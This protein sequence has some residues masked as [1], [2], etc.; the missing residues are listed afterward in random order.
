MK[1]N[2]TVT[3]GRRRNRTLIAFAAAG[4]MSA[5]GIG[6]YASWTANADERPA[7]FDDASSRLTIDIDSLYRAA[8]VD[9]P[10]ND[11]SYIAAVAP[12]RTISGRVSWYGP[13]FHGR[14]TASGERF[15]RNE[16]TAAH[17]TLPFGSLV[18]VVDAST[19]RSVLVRIN[20]RGPY[21]GGRVLDL[22]EEA[23][24]RLGMRRRGTA[25]ARLELYAMPVPPSTDG[26]EDDDAPPSMLTFDAEGQAI[27]PHGYSVEIVRTTDFD[28]AINLQLHLRD[29][30]YGN[31]YLTQIAEKKGK[32][33]YTV[34][35]GLLSSGRL[36]QSLI[37]ELVPQYGGSSIIHFEQGE[38]MPVESLATADAGATSL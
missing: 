18:R 9:E 26:D 25:T 3:P 10:E 27:L 16:M 34:A 35:V 17:K 24:D 22:S 23:A 14:R 2:D 13:G 20:D 37:A 30:G 4:V 28:E 31:V 38:P 29:Q 1:S 7:V 11:S 12:E 36:C 32:F 6:S 15:N 33:T 21:H 19:G 8:A 5:V